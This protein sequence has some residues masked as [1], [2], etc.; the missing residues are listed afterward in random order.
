MT[1][2]THRSSIMGRAGQGR[3]GY[4]GQAAGALPSSSARRSRRWR[5]SPTAPPFRRTTRAPAPELL[6]R[7][8]VSLL[9][10]YCPQPVAVLYHTPTKNLLLILPTSHHPTLYWAKAANCILDEPCKPHPFRALHPPLCLGSAPQ[11][12]QITPSLAFS[13]PTHAWYTVIA[14]CEQ[15][16]RE[17]KPVSP[18]GFRCTCAM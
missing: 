4:Q 13:G 9:G 1:M 6:N 3:A 11:V 7:A 10:P 2:Q 18:R 8:M 16:S 15:K 14:D 5:P 12:S 17:E